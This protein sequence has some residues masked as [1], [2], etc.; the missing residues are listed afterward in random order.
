MA[1]G[2]EVRAIKHPDGFDGCMKLIQEFTLKHPELILVNSKNDMRIVGQETIGL[3]ILQNISWKSPDWISIPAGNGGNL[4]A[5][6]N[7]LVRAKEFG[8]IDHLP[9]IIVGQ[10][11]AADTLVRWQESSYERYEP[12]EYKETI[13]S[14][15]NINDPVSFPRIKKLYAQ[16][17]IHFYRV[18]ENDIQ[19]TWAEFT[20]AGAN[21]VLNL[22]LL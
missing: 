13:A 9:K 10:T 15:M 11:A 7:I 19:R 12:K 5:L 16:F 6:L 18:S 2:A 22:L 14:A 1:H 21:T 4:T 17:D 8:M 3:E 20:R